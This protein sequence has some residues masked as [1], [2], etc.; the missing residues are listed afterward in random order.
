[1]YHREVS[2]KAS[3]GVCFLSLDDSKLTSGHL[4]NYKATLKSCVQAAWGMPL[5][6]LV[7][8]AV[9]I[10]L[11]YCKGSEG[12]IY[13]K[14]LIC[15]YSEISKNQLKFFHSPN[16][17]RRVLIYIH[18]EGNNFWVTHRKPLSYFRTFC[19]LVYITIRNFSRFFLS[20]TKVWVLSCHRSSRRCFWEAKTK[21][22]E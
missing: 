21:C 2:Q 16:Q 1:M 9:L 8:R 14:P 20:F 19:P 3:L 5:G 6:T 17:G 15:I 4:L 13:N 22:P 12:K 11:L 18:G 10:Q 7:P